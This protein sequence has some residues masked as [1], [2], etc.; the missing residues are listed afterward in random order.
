[1]AGH[2]KLLGILHIVFGGL[3]LLAGLAIFAL[4]G[5]I[6]GLVGM[7]G[8]GG[9]SWIA[10]PILGVIGTFVFGLMA[11]LGLP[12]LIAGFGLLSFRP[13]A[14]ILTIVLSALELLNFPFGTILGVY[15]LW[16]LMTPAGERLFTERSYRT[17]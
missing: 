16:V 4:F 6:A 5:G 1:M 7:A 10:V 11:V 9:D 12:G 2:V 8:S 17:V 13:W 15:G 3:A 14:R